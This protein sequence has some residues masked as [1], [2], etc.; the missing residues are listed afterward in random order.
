MSQVEVT[1][2]AIC[3]AGYNTGKLV[4]VN[5]IFQSKELTNGLL[6]CYDRLFLNRFEGN[7][8]HSDSRRTGNGNVACRNFDFVRNHIELSVVRSITIILARSPVLGLLTVYYE[9]TF[10]SRCACGRTGIGELN[11]DCSGN[12]CLEMERTSLAVLVFADRI[13]TFE[14]DS[15][16]IEVF[17]KSHEV[18]CVISIDHFVI[19]ARC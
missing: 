3:N 2:G 9:V 18:L 17:S 8:I 7:I 10:N 19:L 4:S 13:L 11:Y 6:L 5:G 12:S 15:S 16:F 1:K 14:S